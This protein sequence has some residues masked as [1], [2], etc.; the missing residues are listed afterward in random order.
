VRD[1]G[2]GIPEAFRHRIFQK[3]AQADASDARAKGGT[4]LGLSITQAMVERMGGR[5]G[6]TSEPGVLTVFFVEMPQAAKAEG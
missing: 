5:I 6:F 1:H 4:G 2:S 3:F